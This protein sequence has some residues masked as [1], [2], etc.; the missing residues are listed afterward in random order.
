MNNNQKI[1]KELQQYFTKTI[2]KKYD[3]EILEIAKFQNKSKETIL[4]EL[5]QFLLR[6][7]DIDSNG[8]KNKDRIIE[9]IKFQ[10]LIDKVFTQEIAYETEK[11]E[12]IQLNTAKDKF[13]TNEFIYSIGVIDYTLKPVKDD[14]FKK[15]INNKIEGKNFSDRIWNNKNQVAKELKLEINKF[16]NGETDIG[17]ISSKIEKKFNANY[18][19]SN[20]LVRDSIGRVQEEANSEW[21]KEHNIKYVMRDATL[22]KR[23]CSKCAELDQKVYKVGEEPNAI[24]HPNC[25]CTYIS[26]VN[27]DWRPP[28]KWD[29]EAKKRINYTTYEKWK[30]KNKIK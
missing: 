30:K 1:F 19:N 23:T 8:L 28:E 3:A 26:L 2:Y 6:H 9:R 5:G 11:C 7:G 18:Y 29:N 16:L 13:Y 22:D 10:N 17:Q 25:R 24:L 14:V 27:K 15:I 12:E 4:N 21:R 20:R